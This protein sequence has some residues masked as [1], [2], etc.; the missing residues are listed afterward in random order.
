MAYIYH[1]GKKAVASFAPA[2]FAALE[3]GDEIAREILER[4]IKEAVHIIETAAGGFPEGKIP[5]IL[6]GGL[7]KQPRVLES[8]NAL[9]QNPDRFDIQILN[10]A[11][12]NGAVML[13]RE[14]MEEEEK[15]NAGN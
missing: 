2:I 4:N 13:A 7:T 12:V 1:D 9:L 11:P 15:K 5:V 10:S 6:A 14:L 3:K 8:I